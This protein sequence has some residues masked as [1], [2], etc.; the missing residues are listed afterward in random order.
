MQ[1]ITY[2]PPSKGHYDASSLLMRAGDLFQPEGAFMSDLEDKGDHVVVVYPHEKG[3]PEITVQSTAQ[4]VQTVL[5][6]GI[7]VA[8]VAR[9]DGP[10]LFPSDIVLVEHHRGGT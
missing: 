4:D 2:T 9:A 5:A 3:P 8:V 7:A 6:D 1:H 10:Q